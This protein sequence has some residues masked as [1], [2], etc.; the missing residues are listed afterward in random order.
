MK[1]ALTKSALVAL[2]LESI[3]I[4]ALVAVAEK[5]PA[6]AETPGPVVMMTLQPQPDT[7]PVEQ[8]K[9]EKQP[10]P[11]VEPKKLPEPIQPPPKE[12]S[13]PLPKIEET[14]PV[15]EAALP[16]D[17]PTKPV[18]QPKPENTSQTATVSDIFK[19]GVRSAVQAA[20]AYP[21]AA[22][23]A[24]I[25]GKTKVAFNFLDGRVSGLSVV[26]SSGFAM[27]DAAALKA[28]QNASYPAAP[29][30]FSGKTVPFEIWVRFFSNGSAEE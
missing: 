24:H 19:G 21:M 11:K 27:L 17:M 30:E 2:V 25:A 28:V 3:F 22:R 13:D 4:V 14:K 8:P 29:A 26:T 6:E 18:E 15:A 7:P 10:P 12:V 16:V 23:L 9:K 1:F 5:K 20:V